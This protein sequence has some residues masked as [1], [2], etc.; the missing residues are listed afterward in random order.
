VKVMQETLLE[1]DK[2]KVSF[3]TDEGIVKALDGVTF[4]IRQGKILG[5]VGE[6][7]CGK[8]VTAST[9]LRLIPSPP[10]VIEGGRVLFK[11]RN[12]IDLTE[13]ELRHIR[14]SEIAMIFQDP[15]AS[16]NPVHTVG[17]QIMETISLHHDLKG[18]TLLDKAIEMM[19]EVGIPEA[20]RRVSDYPHQFSGGM[21][22]RVMIAMALSCDPDLLIADEPTT[23]LDV[24]IQAQILDMMARLNQVRGTSILLI[25]H[26]LGLISELCHEVAVMYA[27]SIVERAETKVFFR[28]IRH[29][30]TQG[31]LGAIP[32]IHQRRETLT[33][34]SG[35]IP[36][37]IDPPPGC[38]YHPRCPLVMKRCQME[39]PQSIEI[40]P[41]HW[42]ACFKVSE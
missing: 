1:I 31:L 36:D 20:N 11:H 34:I 29:P 6:T 3:H 19:T 30:Y 15:F 41:G 40:A 9:I 12:L 4:E 18:R 22:Q 38:R 7:G 28:D 39:K 35:Q 13:A 16:L 10:G 21:R 17:R 32:R 42:V 26:D 25:S 5:V 37:L 24:T 14:G 27:G 23:A 8:S 2:L 33:V